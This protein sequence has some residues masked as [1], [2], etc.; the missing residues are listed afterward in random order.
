MRSLV[1]LLLILFT[2]IAHAEKIDCTTKFLNFR[3]DQSPNAKLCGAVSLDRAFDDGVKYRK[4]PRLCDK[5]DVE[6]FSIRAGDE[7]KF[8]TYCDEIHSKS[9]YM[10]GIRDNDSHQGIGNLSSHVVFSSI[11]AMP[12]TFSLNA[13]GVGHNTSAVTR[14]GRIVEI[15]L[16]CR[17]S[18][19]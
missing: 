10:V 3:T 14:P 12:T 17:K 4:Q 9:C 11:A 2:A 18:N 1:A 19:N 6:F 7:P 15:N 16:S 13:H 5:F 8:T